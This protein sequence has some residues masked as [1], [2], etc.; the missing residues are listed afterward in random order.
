LRTFHKDMKFPARHGPMSPP[1]QALWQAPM[2]NIFGGRVWKE[3]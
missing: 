1:L 3:G 2:R